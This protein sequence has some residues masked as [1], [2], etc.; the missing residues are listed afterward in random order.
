M[1]IVYFTV[2]HKATCKVFQE[3]MYR[4]S[5]NYVQMFRKISAS[6]HHHC[7]HHAVKGLGLNGVSRI[8][9]WVAHHISK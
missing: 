7:R 2:I 5:R 4:C 1:D 8:V 3:I 6:L 9:E